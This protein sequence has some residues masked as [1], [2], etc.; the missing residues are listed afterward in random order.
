M[1]NTF[2]KGPRDSAPLDLSITSEQ[3]SPMHQ[4]YRSQASMY[5]SKGISS[6][7]FS[8]FSKK[9]ISIKTGQDGQ[10]VNS[11]D[12]YRRFLRESI[13]NFTTRHFSPNNE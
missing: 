11:N 4:R 10:F 13:A 3:S 5:S 8:M 1:K 7:E 9:R 6:N 2:M 12:G